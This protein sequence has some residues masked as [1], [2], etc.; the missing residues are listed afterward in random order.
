MTKRMRLYRDVYR[1]IKTVYVHV[2]KMNK[3]K[4]NKNSRIHLHPTFYS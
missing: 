2:I 3:I 4:T 1:P